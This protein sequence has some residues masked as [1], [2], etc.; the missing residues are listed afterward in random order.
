MILPLNSTIS[1][2]VV[3]MTLLINAT[4][5]PTKFPDIKIVWFSSLIYYNV[6]YLEI[7]IVLYNL[8]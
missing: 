7:K 4:G 8:T 3:L 1:S 6:E 2:H 5:A